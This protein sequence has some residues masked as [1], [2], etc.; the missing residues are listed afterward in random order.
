[1]TNVCS[2]EHPFWRKQ[3]PR[4]SR[5][6]VVLLAVALVLVSGCLPDP[7]RVQSAELLD[8]LALA[9][10]RLAEFPPPPEACNDLGDIETRLYGEPGLMEVQPAW[11]EIA[12]AAHALQAVCGQDALLLQPTT[13]SAVLE[14]ARA[15][16]QQ[17]KQRELGVACDHLRAAAVALSRDAPC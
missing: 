13:G 8:R 16:W 12:D 1:M 11:S 5:V 10:S 3:R 4:H 15:R 6:T 2:V 17:G 7:Q 14:A 9:R